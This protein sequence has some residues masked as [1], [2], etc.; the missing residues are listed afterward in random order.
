MTNHIFGPI[1]KEVKG[2][3][4][5]YMLMTIAIQSWDSVLH[6]NAKAGSFYAINKKKTIARNIS[7]HSLPPCKRPTCAKYC[8]KN[9]NYVTV[10]VVTSMR[11]VSWQALY[12]ALNLSDRWV[13]MFIWSLLNTD[14]IKMSRVKGLYPAP[15]HWLITSEAERA[16]KIDGHDWAAH[17]HM[18]TP[19]TPLS[20]SNADTQRQRHLLLPT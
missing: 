9:M 4:V 13:G 12:I 6:H 18:R 3:V 16:A 5:W 20:P 14:N 19:H 2:L 10:A 11:C 7:S 8:I 17:A 15:L 1:S